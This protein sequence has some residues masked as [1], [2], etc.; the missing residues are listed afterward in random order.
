M[1]RMHE[2]GRWLSPVTVIRET[3]ELVRH[4]R[5]F[6]KRFPT[7]STVSFRCTWKGLN[8]REFTDFNPGVYWSPGR[9]ATASE[10]TVTGEW[11]AVQLGAAWHNIVAELGC[12]VLHL[13]G[14]TECSPEFVAGLAPRFIKL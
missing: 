8:G 11:P 13:F 2:P 10:R 4:A 14:F 9:R 1:A 6:A 3:A 12:P 7:A 5:A